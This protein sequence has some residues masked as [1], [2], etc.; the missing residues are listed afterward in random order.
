[1]DKPSRGATAVK[2]RGLCRNIDRV[3][4][5]EDIIKEIH[6]FIAGKFNL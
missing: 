3:A 5:L 6:N 4:L 2:K 1:M